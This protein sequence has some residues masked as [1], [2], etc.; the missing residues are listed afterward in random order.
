MR[1]RRNFKSLISYIILVNRHDILTVLYKLQLISY[2]K[3]Y[4]VGTWVA[5]AI[6]TYY[7]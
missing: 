4:Y 1:D 7:R 3:R 5:M 6:S 2:D